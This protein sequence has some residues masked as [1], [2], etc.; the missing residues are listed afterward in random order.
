V[1]VPGSSAGHRGHRVPGRNVVERTSCLL[2]QWRG[3]ATRGDEH[4]VTYR[5]AI[6]LAAVI[7]WLR[8]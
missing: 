8:A 7:T 1:S 4:V 3:V 2:K 6:V 5:R